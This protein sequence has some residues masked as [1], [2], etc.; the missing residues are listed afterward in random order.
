VA[1]SAARGSGIAKL[2]YISNV[3]LEG[4]IEEEHGSFEWTA[5]DE[6]VFAFI[7]ELV[8]PVGTYLYGRRPYGTMAVWE[9]DASLAGAVGAD[10]RLRDGLAGGGQGRVLHDPAGCVDR[11]NSPRAQL[12]PRPGP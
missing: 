9:T 3:S 10:G 12:R 7:T 5:P 6:E 2:I 1:S 8:R 11:Q 4:F